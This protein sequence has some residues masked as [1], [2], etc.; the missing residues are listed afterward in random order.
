MNICIM[1]QLRNCKI[2]TVG[3]SEAQINQLREKLELHNIDLNNRHQSTT[4]YIL[5]NRP[6]LG[7]GISII[8]GIRYKFWNENV[9]NRKELPELTV[10]QIINMNEL[11]KRWCI[12]RLNHPEVQE[13]FNENSENPLT[14]YDRELLGWY[15]HYPAWGGYSHTFNTVKENY[16]EITFEQFERLVLNKNN[17]ITLP[18]GEFELKCIKQPKKAKNITEGDDYS[19]ILIDADG[20]QVDSYEDSEYFLCHNNS[21]AE[22]RYKKELF[23]IPVPPKPTV[24]DL[25]GNLTVNNDSV[26]LRWNNTNIRIATKGTN[27]LSTMGENAFSCGILCIKNISALW[28]NTHN[29]GGTNV[30]MDKFADGQNINEIG[31]ILFKAILEKRESLSTKGMYLYSTNYSYPE[32]VRV[33]D[34][35]TNESSQS[36]VNPNSDRLI[37]MWIRYA[38]PV[39]ED[40]F[41]HREPE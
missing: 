17:K 8:D 28:V 34:E 5:P 31:D 36:I 33:M 25:E 14:D 15:T 29:I 39:V 6:D 19:G 35:W 40:P 12:N 3:Y 20:N 1:E 26:T 24:A 22:A 11:P 38:V 2:K 32:L 7:W 9:F 18:M 37:K 16:T 30:L 23:T 21:G 13:W 41:N 27:V 4:I 10:E